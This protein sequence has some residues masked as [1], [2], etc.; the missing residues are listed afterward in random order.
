MP[1]ALLYLDLDNVKTINETFGHRI[2]DAVINQLAAA[3]SAATRTVDVAA[4][5]GGDEFLV[6]LYAASRDDAETILARIREII[7]EVGSGLPVA[8][9]SAGIAVRHAGG[10]TALDTLVHEAERKM[11][12]DK[13]LRRIRRPRRGR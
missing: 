1:I 6:L 10:E 8:D 3:I 9:F 4:R 5:I 13:T 2:G 11:R 7:G 12:D